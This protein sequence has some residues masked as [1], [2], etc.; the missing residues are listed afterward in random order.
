MLSGLKKPKPV[1]PFLSKEGQFDKTAAKG[2]RPLVS[3]FFREA[4]AF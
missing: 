4:L 3:E 1:M 2:I